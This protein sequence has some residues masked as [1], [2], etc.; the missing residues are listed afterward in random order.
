[1]GPVPVLTRSLVQPG[2]RRTPAKSFRAAGGGV[3][4][5][6]GAAGGAAVAASVEGDSQAGDG[7][8]VDDGAAG[9]VSIEGDSSAV[10]EEAS[11]GFGDAVDGKGVVAGEEL[12][13]DVGELAEIAHVVVDGSRCRGRW[14]D[15]SL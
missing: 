6:G 4:H 9:Q 14:C 1:M 13:A 15:R 10:D 7:V 5:E 11:G 12:E 3:G 2:S 8:G